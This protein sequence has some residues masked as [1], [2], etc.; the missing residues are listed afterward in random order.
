MTNKGY[1]QGQV[2][3]VIPVYNEERFLR[4]TLDSVVPQVDCV[5]IS[6]NAST[7]STEAICR[8]YMEKH[9]HVRYFRNERNIG[10]IRSIVS[11]YEKVTTEFVFHLGGHDL[12]PQGYVEELKKLIVA[13]QDCICAFADTINFDRFGDEERFTFP[14]SKCFLEDAINPNPYFRAWRFFYYGFSWIPL[15]GIF[16]SQTFLPITKNFQ[17][18]PNCD[19]AILFEALLH[20]TFLYSSNTTY[21]RRDNHI[22]QTGN[23]FYDDAMKRVCGESDSPPCL[24]T[25]IRPL[26]KQVFHVYRKYHNRKYLSTKKE[27]DDSLK[28]L[29]SVYTGEKTG[30]IFHDLINQLKYRWRNSRL[31]AKWKAFVVFIKRNCLPSCVQKRK[32]RKDNYG[33]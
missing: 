25:D 18:I 23:E 7:D 6:D 15:Y 1:H 12:I 17:L 16:R 28:I 10:S 32:Y 2:T 30:S 31:R 11:C 24:L 14:N 21:R 22:D 9:P 3:A 33:K 19:L 13:N 20:G 4:E 5:I 26:A 8:E 29:F 27:Y